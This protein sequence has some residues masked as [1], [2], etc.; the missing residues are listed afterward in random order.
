MKLSGFVF[1]HNNF[2]LISYDDVPSPARCIHYLV[3]VSFAINNYLNVLIFPIEFMVMKTGRARFFSSSAN[4]NV[5][6]LSD[7]QYS[8]IENIDRVSDLILV[9]RGSFPNTQYK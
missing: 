1:E 7:K 4:Q 3:F 8:N 5:A 6:A 2:F 9:T